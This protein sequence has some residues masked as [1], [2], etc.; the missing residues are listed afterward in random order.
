M[1]LIILKFFLASNFLTCTIDI[2]NE[3]IGHKIIKKTQLDILM[4]KSLGLLFPR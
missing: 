3:L 1:A 4:N 2:I